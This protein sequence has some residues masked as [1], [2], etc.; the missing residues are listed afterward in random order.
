MTEKNSQH[1]ETLNARQSLYRLSHPVQSGWD[2]ESEKTSFV[3]VSCAN[4][5]GHRN[6][7]LV[8]PARE[9]GSTI[10]MGEIGGCYCEESH[11]S[12][13]A[14]MGFPLSEGSLDTTQ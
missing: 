8:F 1:V 12:A 11:A 6:E 2:D 13:L 7:I 9:D 14:G 5:Y 4:G 3:L 10:S